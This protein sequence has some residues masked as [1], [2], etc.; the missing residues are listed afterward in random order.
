[1]P[2]TGSRHAWYVT[3]ALAFAVHNAE[4]AIAASR[5]LTFMQS[6]GPIALRAFYVGIT[7]AELRASLV[8]LTL[9]GI[10]VMAFALRFQQKPRWSY[11]M[12]VFAAVIGLNALGHVA[13]SSIYRTYIPGLLTALIVTMPVAVMVLVRARR[14]KW[15]P[16]R[17]YWTLLPMALVMHGPILFLVIQTTIAGFR[18]LTGGAA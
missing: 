8:V 14:D 1:M 17:M 6:S 7:P 9:L 11:A 16:S 12:L 3:I 10:I 18:A 4:E 13:L 5:L 2:K 15:V